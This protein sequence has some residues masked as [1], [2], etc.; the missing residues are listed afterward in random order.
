MKG[1]KIM[2]ILN[3]HGYRGNPDN[4]SSTA[5]KELNH[6]VVSPSIDFDAETPDNIYKNLSVILSEKSVDIIVGTSLGGFFAALLSVKNNL[7]VIL[8]N[9]CLMPFLTLKKLDYKGDVNSFIPM[10]W[11]LSGLKSY[12]VRA[13]VGCK[14]E[15]IDT[16][17]IAESLFPD[18]KFEKISDGKHSGRTLPLKDFFKES[19]KYV[20]SVEFRLARKCDVF[21]S[22]VSKS[23][24]EKR[25]T[26]ELFKKGN[27]L[28]WTNLNGDYLITICEF[29]NNGMVRFTVNE[30]VVPYKGTSS[31]EN[32]S[33]HV[34]LSIDKMY[35]LDKEGLDELYNNAREFNN[36]E[37][38]P[39]IAGVY[40]LQDETNQKFYVG[41]AKNIKWRMYD[42][43][44]KSS[45]SEID[46]RL[47][48][49]DEIIS[50]KYIPLAGSGYSN[51]DAL[52]VAFIAYFDSY[53]NGY[54]S[55][56]GN[57]L[58]LDKR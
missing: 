47:Y 17:N 35:I 28:I 54:N 1:S 52:E 25:K 42:H 41:Q 44:Q 14:D 19:I 11:E 6:E 50:K 24:A 7:P 53:H 27:Q 58:L 43:Y 9:P 45:Y 21:D 8:V 20:K 39:E 23:I 36:K 12:N 33:Y 22:A 40:I 2:I 51:L 49:E 55:T 34:P 37:D 48:K 10:F 3:I 32:E 57:K 29:K 31:L 15:I 56:R 38:A 26:G 16:H 5:L 4:A 18:L 30:K 46:N 13:I